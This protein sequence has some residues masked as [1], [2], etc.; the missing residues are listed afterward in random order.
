MAAPSNGVTRLVRG[1]AVVLCLAV[2]A[3]FAAPAAQAQVPELPP[4]PEPVTTALQQVQDA[5]IPVL[6]QVSTAAQPVSNAGGFALRPGC[7]G[8]GTAVLL[9]V[10]LGGSLPFSP[11]FV[12]T[13]VLIFCAGAFAP[14][15]ADPVFSQVDQAAGAQAYGLAEPVLDQVGAALAPARPNLADVCGAVALA[16]STP[17]QVPPPLNRFNLIQTV[18]TG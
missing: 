12:S 9:A 17:N 4:I 1:L 8:V 13:P 11:G 10:L 5:A 2:G 6:I 3:V 15:P 7:A 14:G 16:G 18:C